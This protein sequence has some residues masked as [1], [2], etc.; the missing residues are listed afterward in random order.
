VPRLEY[1]E[2]WLVPREV[3]L[4]LYHP[5]MPFTRGLIFL[6]RTLTVSESVALAVRSLA[7]ISV[8]AIDST[9]LL[10]VERM[11]E[12]TEVI[13]SVSTFAGIRT[14]VS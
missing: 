10:N 9:K 12:S 3:Y 14:I 1:L 7:S 5:K 8:V 11:N 6:S 13:V 4:L 2:V